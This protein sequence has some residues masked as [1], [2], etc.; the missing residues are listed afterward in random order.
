MSRY[1]PGDAYAL[2]GGRG[3]GLL[4]E[5]TALPVVERLWRTLVDGGG[6]AEVLEVIVEE[7]GIA[8]LPGFA[9]AVT[10]G[11][12][13]VD[14]DA[15]T[16][17]VV[18]GIFEARLSEGETITA[19][20]PTFWTE[21]R[22]IDAGAVALS[23]TG[24]ATAE[25]VTL[26]IRS[27]V[28]RAAAI[29]TDPAV[30]DVPLPVLPPP[31]PVPA[32]EPPEPLA[33]PAPEPPAPTPTP[34]APAPA[35]VVPP[36]LETQ[37]RPDVTFATTDS[38][39]APF[40]PEAPATPP[41]APLAEL[42]VEEGTTTYDDLVFGM[43]RLTSVEDAAVRSAADEHDAVAPIGSIPRPG[44]ALPPALPEPAGDH[45][46][47]TLSAEQFA[48][49]MSGSAPASPSVAPALPSAVPTGAHAVLILPTGER[50]L[51]DRGAVVGVRPSAVRTS[52]AVP[53]LIAV[54]SPSGEISRRHLEIRVE[55]TDV[56]AVDLNST[57][58][59][60]LLRVGADPVRMHPGAA[61]LLV[62]GDRLD[63]GDGVVLSFEGLR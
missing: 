42:P 32:P 15:A 41:T 35:P 27:G 12:P 21:R 62:G 2:S 5:D 57:N 22:L 47:L 55:G 1:E 13:D 40:P 63:L 16:R 52:S 4:A 51:L 38:V 60:R 10:D 20:A 61:T 8:R 30:R 18:R 26:P 29:S 11:D 23:V 3:V 59:T 6:L 56:L 33:S 24:A 34:T 58:G 49:L 37:I 28:V 44:T 17:V 25:A 9:F 31:T 45:D 54:A 48:A 46:G 7:Y 19:D 39:S 50:T 53:H 14:V 36:S 43:T